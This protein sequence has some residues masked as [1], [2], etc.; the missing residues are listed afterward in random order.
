MPQY[1]PP[2]S[3]TQS[4]TGSTSQAICFGNAAELSWITASRRLVPS[5]RLAIECGIRLSIAIVW[6]PVRIA[7]CSCTNAGWD[8]P[9]SL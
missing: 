7:S 1:T 2:R 3:S 5:A 9:L 8:R 6:T 4:L